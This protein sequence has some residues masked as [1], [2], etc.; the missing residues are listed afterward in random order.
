MFESCRGRHFPIW[1]FL[2]Q[3]AVV[4]G[5]VCHSAHLLAEE[6][7]QRASVAT[8][9]PDQDPRSQSRGSKSQRFDPNCSAAMS[10]AGGSAQAV[11]PPS[12]VLLFSK[13]LLFSMHERKPP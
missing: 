8:S 10:D 5:A 12:S 4:L 11:L 3:S 6:Y 2:A 1:L 13:T 9:S 7:R